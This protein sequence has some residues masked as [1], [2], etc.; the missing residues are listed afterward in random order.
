M[1]DGRGVGDV[2]GL[3]KDLGV[4]LL[5]DVLRGGLQSLLVAGAHG[6]AATLGGE[7][8]R[9][10]TANPLTGSGHQSDTIFQAEIHGARIIKGSEPN[11]RLL[12]RK[13]PFGF[14]QGRL[15]SFGGSP[16]PS[17]RRKRLLGMTSALLRLRES[18]RA[19]NL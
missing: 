10:G 14:T 18:G 5:S 19:I 1:A 3:G 12:R 13:E 15:R 8:F 11:A 17:L 7:G 9:G 2:E 16:D 4:I 6:D